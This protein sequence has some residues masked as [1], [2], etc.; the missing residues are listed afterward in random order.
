MR[1]AIVGTDSSLKYPIARALGTDLQIPIFQG[2]LDKAVADNR[3]SRIDTCSPEQSYEF[4]NE[5]IVAHASDIDKYSDGIFTLTSVEILAYYMMWCVEGCSEELSRNSIK[6][7]VHFAK[8]YD[9]IY[10]IVLKKQTYDDAKKPW[11][12]TLL[13]D[14]SIEYMMRGILHRFGINHYIIDEDTLEYGKNAIMETL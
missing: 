7:L 4:L 12:G 1:L 9:R 10:L 6:N 13:F 5:A 8:N 11:G 3:V 2:V 14:Y